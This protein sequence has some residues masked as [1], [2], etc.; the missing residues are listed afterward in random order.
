MRR[1]R[2]GRRQLLANP[3]S[4]SLDVTR[5]LVALHSSDPVTVYLSV[6]ARLDPFAISDLETHLYEKRDLLRIYGMRRTLWVV[7][8]ETLPLVDRSSTNQ[9]AAPNRRRFEKML[10]N[11]GVTN[12]PSPWLDRVSDMTLEAIQRHGEVLARDLT[13]EIPELANKLEFYNKAG[14]LTGSSGVSTRMLV[15]LGLESRVVRGRPAGSWI[16]SQYRWASME[17][18]L[19]GPMPEL[20]PDM[21]AMTLLEKW[22]RQFGP[23]TTRDIRWWTGWT[24]ARVTRALVDVG[25]VEV[26]L[27][28]DTGWVLPDDLEEDSHGDNWVALLPSLDPTTMGWKDRDW[29]LGPHYPFLFDRNGNAGPTVWVNGQVVGGWAQRNTGEVVFELL[30]D[31]GSEAEAAIAEKASALEDWLGEARVTP[32][33]RSPHDKKLSAVALPS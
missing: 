28:D 4:D 27:E 3:G 8:R 24:A 19:G 29:Y 12:E 6:R 13:E 20:D 1:A 22:L 7:D 16:S 32:R 26:A 30:E 5:S 9:I 31:V 11:G 21:A 18:W 2:L 15:Q 23:G 14:K 17:D 25:A 10:V 33:F